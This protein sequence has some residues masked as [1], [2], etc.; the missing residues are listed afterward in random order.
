MGISRKMLALCQGCQACLT[1]KNQKIV[2]LF[3]AEKTKPNT[4][5]I[6]LLKI[7]LIVTHLRF[8]FLKQNF[9]SMFFRLFKIVQSK[10]HHMV[11]P[12]SNNAK[13]F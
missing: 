8:Y 9:S 1:R 13:T 5:K 7:F 11:V 12:Y 6:F 3:F 4:I 2:F 10:T